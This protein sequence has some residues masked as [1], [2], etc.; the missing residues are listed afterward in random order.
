[1]PTS[2][3]DCRENTCPFHGEHRNERERNQQTFRQVVGEFLLAAEKRELQLGACNSREIEDIDTI[4]AEAP[5]KYLFRYLDIVEAH[6]PKLASL[7]RKVEDAT[8]ELHS[9][10]LSRREVDTTKKG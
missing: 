1:M 6:D 9:H 10:I 7:I 8:M 4:E 5:P 2:N 3:H